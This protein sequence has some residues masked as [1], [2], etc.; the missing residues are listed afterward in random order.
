MNLE[1]IYNKNIDYL[2]QHNINFYNAINET[3]IS[4]IKIN[5]SDNNINLYIDNKPLYPKNTS[6][7]LGKKIEDFLPYPQ[8]LK[9]LQ[10]TMKTTQLNHP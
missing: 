3:D 2:K 10:H 8:H 9:K 7:Y 5:I 4:H 1:K 6:E